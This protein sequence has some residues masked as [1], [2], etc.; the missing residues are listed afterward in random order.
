MQTWFRWPTVI[1]VCQRLG[2]PALWF[3]NPSLL[4]LLSPVKV[5]TLSM[6]D[7]DFRSLNIPPKQQP[8]LEIFCLSGRQHL[9]LKLLWSSLTVGVI[10]QPLCISVEPCTCICLSS[11]L[12][13]HII[14]ASEKFSV[15]K[16]PNETVFSLITRH[17]SV[18]GFRLFCHGDLI[19]SPFHHS[20][21]PA[22]GFQ[23]LRIILSA[24][25]LKVKSFH[26]SFTLL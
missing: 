19:Q 18:A 11:C 1:L 14:I 25:K 15:Y 9:N 4:S 2:S 21:K 17:L 16:G 12:Q 10:A 8:R 13:L 24:Y 3:D 6:T 20:T 23:P 22:L 7:P 26:F 5:N